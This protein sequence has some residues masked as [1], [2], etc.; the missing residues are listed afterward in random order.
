MGKTHTATAA[1]EGLEFLI[2]QWGGTTHLLL[3]SPAPQNPQGHLALLESQLEADMMRSDSLC[4]STQP[5]HSLKLAGSM[6]LD[7]ECST[8]GS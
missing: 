6:G 1:S 8:L 4:P 7:K 2:P 5:V 3:G